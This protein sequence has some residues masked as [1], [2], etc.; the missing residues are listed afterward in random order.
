ML[1]GFLSFDDA[2]NEKLYKKIT[3][4]KFKTSNF[5]TDSAK[6]FLHRILNVEPKT[7]ITI[8]KMTSLV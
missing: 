6:D 2:D 1:F 4:G 7:R 5:L 8:P 3:K